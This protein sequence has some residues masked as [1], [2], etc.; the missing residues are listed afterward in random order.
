MRPL[1]RLG[2]VLGRDR[3]GGLMRETLAPGTR[4]APS[5]V[6]RSFGVVHLPSGEEPLVGKKHRRHQR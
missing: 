2:G 5:G 1:T 4:V 3:G 6:E